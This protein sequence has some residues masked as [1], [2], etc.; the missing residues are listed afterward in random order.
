MT[1]GAPKAA[2]GGASNAF[3]NVK[4]GATTTS[5]PAPAK[6]GLF[7]RLTAPVVDFAKNAQDAAAI[8][9]DAS[10][11]TNHG[12]LIVTAMAVFRADSVDESDV[13]WKKPS[14]GATKN[15]RNFITCDKA[16]PDQTTTHKTL[17]RGRRIVHELTQIG[18]PHGPPSENPDFEGLGGG[19]SNGGKYKKFAV[20]I[21]GQCSPD[22]E[23]EGHKV[24]RHFD[25]S[26]QNDSNTGGLFLFGPDDLK[27]AP[28]DKL[29]ARR[30]AVDEMKATCKHDGR[31]A[32]DGRLEVVEGDEVELEI[33]WV[34]A[35][36]T[37]P[38][39]RKRP[40]CQIPLALRT[41]NPKVRHPITVVSR[42]AHDL[43]SKKY[44]ALEKTFNGT[45]V[46]I[47]G[48][49]LGE[50]ENKDPEALEKKKGAHEEK[51]AKA[52]EAAGEK[53]GPGK[54]ET[55]EREAQE[56]GQRTV[57]RV[58]PSHMDGQ[59]ASRAA[60]PPATQEQLG[61][62][63]RSN[64]EAARRDRNAQAWQDHLQEQDNKSRLNAA[65]QADVGRAA[66]SDLSKGVAA[67]LK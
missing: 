12:E 20:A 2:P 27:Q 62:R 40:Q 26:K 53:K 3:A 43:V 64:G 11:L 55:R 50:D 61:A 13:L 28:L 67:G 17:C 45:T 35:A 29:R 10:N 47:E 36:A 23:A 37:K 46:K 38:E 54:H 19:V 1:T 65:R 57:E 5:A 24:V 56:S 44:E 4:G 7:D 15:H 32:K 31:E 41:T 51:E 22:T 48:E 9:G 49:M 21:R 25:P 8:A 39:D 16:Q 59:T 30:C 63:V 66:A 6:P 18:D 33:E 58:S 34:N 42:K 52:K 14:K 60:S